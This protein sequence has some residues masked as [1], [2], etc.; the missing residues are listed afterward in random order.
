MRATVRRPVRAMT[1]VLGRS[2]K[3]GR[4]GTRANT[5]ED[6]GTL[7]ET[8]S[9]HLE[10]GTEIV[11]LRSSNSQRGG[12]PSEVLR[13]SR[14]SV[15]LE[16]AAAV[17]PAWPVYS[18]ERIMRQILLICAA[19]IVGAKRPDWLLTVAKAT[20]FVLTGWG[21]CVLILSLAYIQK[22]LASASR[23]LAPPL[24]DEHIPLL[25][26]KQ[27]TTGAF[28]PEEADENDI[29]VAIEKDRSMEEA[30]ATPVGEITSFPLSHPA[31]DCLYIIDPVSGKRIM[32]NSEEPARI[33]SEWFDMDMLVLIR[34]P[35]VDDPST[36]GGTASNNKVVNYLRGK[37][38][39]FEFQWRVKLKKVPKDKALYF[40]CELNEPIKMGLIQRA[41]VGA[42]MAFV[43][44]SNP[45][46]H[47]SILG[48]KDR[49]T[50]GKWEK[51]HMSF[52]VEEG[53]DRLVVTKPGETPPP[54]GESIYEDPESMKRRLK[55]IPVDWNT[56]DTY[57]LAVYSSYVDF[58]DW[59]VINLPG[60][61]PFGLKSVL[62]SQSI[63]FTLY[64]IDKKKLSDKHYRSDLTTVLDIELSNNE[65]ASWGPVAKK[66]AS[67]QQRM[68]ALSPKSTEKLIGDIS[69]RAIQFSGSG[70]GFKGEDIEDLEEVDEDA[71]TAAELGEGIYLR[72][73][74]SVVLRE[75]VEVEGEDLSPCSVA[76][77]GGFAILQDQDTCIVIKKVAR[78]K[79]NR[80]IKSGDTVMFKM[81]QKSVE[82]TETRYLTI[83]R[84][85]Y[86]KWVLTPPTKNGSFVIDIVEE[87]D[88]EDRPGETESSFLT[89]GGSFKLRH[90]RWSNYHVGVA[91]DPS[92]TYGGRM[93]GLFNP[94]SN[95]DGYNA[96]EQYDSDEGEGAELDGD[97]DVNLR[98]GWMKPLV[99]SA[100][101]PG[102]LKHLKS[103]SPSP[104]GNSTFTFTDGG[105]NSSEHPNSFPPDRLIF[106]SEHS[107]VDV[108]AW[109]EMMNRTERVRQLTYVV[110]VMHRKPAVHDEGEMADSRPVKERSSFVKLRTGRELAKIMAIG[111]KSRSEYRRMERPDSAF[112]ETKHS[113]SRPHRNTT[114]EGISILPNL[115]SYPS[116]SPTAR[117]S[118]VVQPE[119]PL[120]LK[121]ELDE[122]SVDSNGN[123]AVDE[124][125]EEEENYG[126]YG[127]GGESE[128]ESDHEQ[129]EKKRNRRAGQ[130]G[131][132]IMGKVA[133]TAK[134]A[135]VGT[136]KLAAKTGKLT[137]KVAVGAALGT[138]KAAKGVVA[139]IS[140]KSKKPPKS[141]PKVKREKGKGLR[142][143][144]EVS[145]TM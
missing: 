1:R 118:N 51:A 50:N 119:L 80:L 21:T 44:S 2:T 133:K 112:T 5:V 55:G 89:L 58:L 34:T 140:R 27:Q 4:H 26:N 131:K 65:K 30:P 129:E 120:E 82:K 116:L 123:E 101:D 108:P 88:K 99:L 121:N 66:W 145:K 18:M 47:Y 106:S 124:R 102:S 98:K 29:E 54:L 85:W 73:G 17:D 10:E 39:R 12:H 78:S 42:A 139:P 43:K 113:P 61:R 105:E 128:S 52:T 7:V 32:A 111:K 25:D 57:T 8:A 38:R 132:A 35:D 90:K 11:L 56:E 20:E 15:S 87:E 37:Q 40:A 63:G 114:R 100:H 23:E 67:A 135:T 115:E 75:F 109:I 91:A 28:M 143:H 36:I 93:L 134:S 6:Y 46:F 9:E 22:R 45:S 69:P 137:G 70:D 92:I 53:L 81:I 117:E 125:Y 138:V 136:T 110:R 16:P 104:K 107:Q 68:Q 79:R 31:L 14:S 24:A 94:K 84:G 103:L 144:K 33:S 49:P 141:E 126:I 95:N 86:L 59:K 64:M 71:E 62:G 122:G 83:H 96:G 60:I 72:S 3:T 13:S 97:L 76:N 74:D 48:S 130:K 142:V 41:F 19:Y 127:D 77:G